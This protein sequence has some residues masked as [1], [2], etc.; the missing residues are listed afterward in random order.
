[1]AVKICNQLLW[2]ISMNMQY[3]YFITLYFNNGDVD[4]RQMIVDFVSDPVPHRL[5]EIMKEQLS[6]G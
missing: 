3:L 1:M 6:S 2:I 4:N 5:L